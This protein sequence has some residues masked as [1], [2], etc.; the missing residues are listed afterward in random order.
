MSD[1]PYSDTERT[2]F[3]RSTPFISVSMGTVTRRSTSSAAWPGHCVEISTIG[4]DRSGYASTGRRLN[5][6]VPTA[7]S[8]IVAMAT[9]N[10]CFSAARTIRL[11]NDGGPAGAAGAG[12]GVG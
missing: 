1:S 2:T 10:G 8:V 4:G 3:T 5:D 7:I 9:R 11:A 6:Q 12:V